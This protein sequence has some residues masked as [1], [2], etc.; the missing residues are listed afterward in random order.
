MATTKDMDD[1]ESLVAI[2]TRPEPVRARTMPLWKVLLHNDDVSDMVY[3]IETIVMLT[4]L[5]EQDAARH[6]LEAHDRGLTLLLTTHRERAE[7]YVD[8][9]SSRD[10]VVTIEPD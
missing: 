10:L 4:T 7:L 2:Q 6:M 8:Q 3:V 1:H 9:F 5:N